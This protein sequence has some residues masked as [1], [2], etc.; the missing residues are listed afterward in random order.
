H[1][2]QP[3]AVRLSAYDASRFGKLQGRVAHVS[4]DVVADT[5]SGAAHFLVRIA[6]GRNGLRA[7]DGRTLPIVP[8]MEAEVEL[9]GRDR[10]L[11]SYLLDP[12]AQLR[13]KAFR[14]R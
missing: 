14:E 9:I 1:V 7:A 3:A 5:R 6:I 2:G 12:V 11:S 4:P 13:D 8:G 10:S